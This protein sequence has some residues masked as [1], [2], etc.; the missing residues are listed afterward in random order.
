[1]AVLRTVLVGSKFRGRDAVNA[2]IALREGDLIRLKREPDNQY[3]GNA[4][5]CEFRGMHIGYLP[6]K[7]NAEI[8]AALD[9]RWL[10]TCVVTDEAITV[11]GS[12]REVP[13]LTVSW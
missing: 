7:Q 13:R 3:D 9:A 11:G 5:A 10:V 4:V 2:A 8:A 1:M 6:S 12:I